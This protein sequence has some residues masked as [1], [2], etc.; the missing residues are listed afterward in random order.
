M[1]FQKGLIKTGPPTLNVGCTIPWQ[2]AQTVLRKTTQLSKEYSF[3]SLPISLLQMQCDMVFH[4]PN[5]PMMTTVD[6]RTVDQN[7]PFLLWVTSVKHFVTEFRKITNI[8]SNF[9]HNISYYI[10]RLSILT[11]LG[12]A[13]VSQ[14]MHRDSPR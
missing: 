13:I 5:S 2:V 14:L 10:L 9:I 4:V 7:K 6:P 1:V 3:I 11:F 12:L 8:L